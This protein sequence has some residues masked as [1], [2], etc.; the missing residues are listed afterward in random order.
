M[1]SGRVRPA[2]SVAERIRTTPASCS[3]HAIF[4]GMLRPLDPSV[5]RTAAASHRA[6]RP[7]FTC[8]TGTPSPLEMITAFSLTMTTSPG[9]SDAPRCSTMTAP[10][11]FPGLIHSVCATARL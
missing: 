9:C 3:T 6:S 8:S 4:S 1:P 11:S 5:G 7:T 10:R 2:T